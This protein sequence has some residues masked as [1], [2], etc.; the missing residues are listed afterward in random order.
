[1]AAPVTMS[2]EFVAARSQ[3]APNDNQTQCQRQQYKNCRNG[4]GFAHRGWRATGRLLFLYGYFRLRGHNQESPS[5]QS[6]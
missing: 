6:S 5:G 4:I 2:G 1:V 3:L